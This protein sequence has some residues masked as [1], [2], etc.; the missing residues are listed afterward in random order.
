MT[1]SSVAPTSKAEQG[2]DGRRRARLTVLAGYGLAVVVLFGVAPL[3]LSDFRLR[4]LAQFLCLAM[5]AVGIGLEVGTVERRRSEQQQREVPLVA[6][7]SV[8]LAV[9]VVVERTPVAE[10]R[11]GIEGQLALQ[12]GGCDS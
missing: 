8:H 2:G 4:L 6:D 10:P 5:V 11:Q 9:E 12:A 3:V 7:G 1:T